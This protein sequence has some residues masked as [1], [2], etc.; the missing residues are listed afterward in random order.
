[1]I[2]GIIQT[3]FEGVIKR[4]SAVGRPGETITDREYFQHYG[5]TSRPLAGAEGII[6]REGNHIVMIASD[7]RRYRI[8]LEDGEVAL[9]TDEGDYLHFKR[10][11]IIE[12]VCGNKIVATAASE[13]E[14]TAPQVKIAASTRVLLET[15][16]AEISGSLSVGGNIAAAGTI[17]DAT[18]AMN[19]DRAIYND[20]THP[21]SGG[22]TGVPNQGM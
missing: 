3:V 4:F 14:I 9:Y 18:R 5:F 6:I 19:A 12:V 10:G 16:L 15:P 21:A 1:M 22:D 8:G 13:A 17:S 11:R 20:H 7:D 2:R